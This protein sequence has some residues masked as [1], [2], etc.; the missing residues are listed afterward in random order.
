MF[1][2]YLKVIIMLLS[3]MNK[4]IYMLDFEK[5]LRILKERE[6]KLMSSLNNTLQAIKA[7]IIIILITL[8]IIGYLL[9]VEMLSLDNKVDMRYYD[10]KETLALSTGKWVDERTGKIFYNKS[11]YDAYKSQQRWTKKKNLVQKTFKQLAK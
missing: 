3:G 6:V 11:E 9:R 2:I 1:S 8:F 7:L 5:E 10:L 4:G